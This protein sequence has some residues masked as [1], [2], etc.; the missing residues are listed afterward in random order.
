MASPQLATLP[1]I[2]PRRTS[3]FEC[4]IAVVV[5][6]CHIKAVPVFVVSTAA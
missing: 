2:T 5:T 1:V 4:T 3:H 6:R